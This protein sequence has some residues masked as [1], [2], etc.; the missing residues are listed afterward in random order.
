MS[1]VNFARKVG[2]A[3]AAL[4]LIMGAVTVAAVSDVARAQKGP[5]TLFLVLIADLSILSL[6]LLIIGKQVIGL[7]VQRRQGMAGA[8]LHGRLVFL[9]GLVAIIP[10]I[11]IASFSVGFFHYGLQPLFNDR[12]RAAVD[13]SRWVATAYLREHIDAIRGE[14][15]STQ[16]ALDMESWR[17][18]YPNLE[19]KTKLNDRLKRLGWERRLDEIVLFMLD[20]G[21]QARWSRVDSTGQT[22][23][24][25]NIWKWAMQEARL[26]R[27]AVVA[28]DEMNMVH[29]L[30]RLDIKNHMY[31]R[32]SRRIEPQVLDT[33]QRAR[34]AA[35]EFLNVLGQQSELKLAS[36][37]LIAV[38]SL[39]FLLAAIWIG[40][41]VATHLVAPIRTLIS[42]A[43]SVQQGDLSARVEEQKIQDE[44][45]ILTRTFNRMIEQLNNQR[46]D[47][48]QAHVQTENRRAFTEAVLAGVSAAVI[49]IDADEQVTLVNPTALELLGQNEENL[50][51][52]AVKKIIPEIT[53]ILDQAKHRSD[54]L[55]SGQITFSTSN[56]RHRILLVRIT[57]Q[58]TGGHNVEGYVIMLNEITE[59]VSAQ[60]QAAWADVAR[61]IAHEIKNPLTPIQLSAERLK[62]KYLHQ[63]KSDQNIFATCTDTIVRQVGDIRR[64]VDEFSAFARMPAPNMRWERL[65]LLCREALIL[66]SEAHPQIEFIFEPEKQIENPETQIKNIDSGSLE[67]EK[68]PNGKR[69]Q[70]LYSMFC[71]RR[72]L[73]QVL[74]NILQNAIDSISED[75]TI[76]NNIIKADEAESSSARII[77][78]LS[79]YKANLPDQEASFVIQ[80]VDNGRGLPKERRDQLT[81][82]YVT[83]RKK[84]TG[85]GLAIVRKIMEDHHGTISLSDGMNRGAVVTL[86]FPIA[87]RQES[88]IVPAK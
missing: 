83:T 82:P 46:E 63:I 2:I 78:K 6:L 16:L 36:A 8:R 56:D 42:A 86:T 28:E 1:Q 80:I 57:A 51:R 47:L 21:V 15:L 33:V 41:S 84:G 59:L 40:I 37:V 67:Q 88:E 87:E 64:M 19:Q 20:K 17:F 31:L 77:I 12:I 76:R 48:V 68:K 11:V 60:R 45:G 38:V 81:E 18:L 23:Q 61:R 50:L 79:Y 66:Q 34:E 71:D 44:L 54:G 49:G 22:V 73:G 58:H 62:R 52:Q 65:D 27:V 29:G 72:Q 35:A 53:D 24:N 10:A 7:W 85:L 43:E 13:E 5:D 9:F 39:L 32:V 74:T 70:F 55:S 75:S 30:V 25:E 14:V 26:G 4:A 69:D 3:L